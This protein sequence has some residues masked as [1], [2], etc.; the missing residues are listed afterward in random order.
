MSDPIAA[1][2]NEVLRLRGTGHAFARISRELGLTRAVDAQ[3]AFQRAVRQLPAGERD[4]VCREED[5]RLDRLAAQVNADSSLSVE[6][7]ARRLAVVER[8]RAW[9][10]EDD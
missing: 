10:V 3:Q 8:L 7:R 5:S 9:M 4:R 2:D 6:D 1:T